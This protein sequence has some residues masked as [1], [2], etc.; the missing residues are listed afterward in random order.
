MTIRIGDSYGVEYR[1]NFSGLQELLK[2][3]Q[4]KTI[5][6]I[7]A[8]KAVQLAKSLAP[9]K[10]GSFQA[11]IHAERPKNVEFI[12]QFGRPTRRSAVD[13]VADSSDA[14]TVE[15]GAKQRY[16][17]GLN[18]VGHHTLGQTV[19]ILNGQYA[20]QVRK[21]LE[22]FRARNVSARPGSPHEGPGSPGSGKETPGG[23]P[24]SQI[25]KSGL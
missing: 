2:S 6:R 11:S 7:E 25:A 23:T 21:E 8:L 16:R 18:M 22:L 19:K 14:L 15:F 1:P 3:E 5:L 24:Y 13:I 17:D 4:M 9:R 12:N 10:K 20:I